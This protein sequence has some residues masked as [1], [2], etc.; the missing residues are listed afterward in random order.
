MFVWFY[1]LIASGLVIFASSMTGF[2][3]ARSYRERP[4][5]LRAMQSV[6]QGL[7]TEISYGATPLPEAFA[8]LGRTSQ[9]PV[10]DLFF[11]AEETLR[12]PGSTANEAW[13]R[14]LERLAAGSALL[15]SDLSI[16]SQ[17]GSQLGLSDRQDQERHLLLAVQQLAREESR[18]EEARQ[19]N[20][21][22]WRYLGVLSGILLVIVLL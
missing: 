17:L 9:R 7:A 2:S 16:L 6:L 21:R 12:Q 4:R 20:E 18:A 22:M 10:A 5:H 8:H 19:S 13:Q 1:K 15:K 3:V 11:A 14:G